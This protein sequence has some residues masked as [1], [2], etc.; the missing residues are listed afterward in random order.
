M[1]FLEIKHCSGI[2]FILKIYFLF[3]FSGFS[4]FWTGPQIQ[5]NPGVSR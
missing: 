4:S 5:R 2:I 3:V 1:N